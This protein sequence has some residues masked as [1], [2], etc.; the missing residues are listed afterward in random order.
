[1]STS[2]S[3]DM[4]CQIY[5]NQCFPSKCNKCKPA[6][7][8][9]HVQYDSQLI[10]TMKF[11]VNQ[12]VREDHSNINLYLAKWDDNYYL[13][14]KGKQVLSIPI[15]T[16]NKI[17]KPMITFNQVWLSQNVTSR[18]SKDAIAM[19]ISSLQLWRQLLGKCKWTT[20]VFST[21]TW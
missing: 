19:S 1:M 10:N 2:S 18:Q 8:N 21:P 6:T 15:C 7:V 3:H 12:M 5:Q 17:V 20:W 9:S 16:M 13:N 14:T 11:P 4:I